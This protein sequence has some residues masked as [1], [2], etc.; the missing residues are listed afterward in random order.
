MIVMEGGGGRNGRI[1]LH[2]YGDS[3]LFDITPK[4][5]T[6]NERVSSLGDCA[7]GGRVWFYK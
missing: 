2:F 1:K 5:R 6:M 3:S 7:S 4:Y